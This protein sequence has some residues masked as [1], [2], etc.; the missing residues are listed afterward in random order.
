MWQPPNAGGFWGKKS[1]T[2]TY[3]QLPDEQ[4]QSG[5]GKA[6]QSLQD[7][8]IEQQIAPETKPAALSARPLLL[9]VSL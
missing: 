8:S 6:R 4:Q 7:P 1:Y 9:A 5:G 3:E 2:V